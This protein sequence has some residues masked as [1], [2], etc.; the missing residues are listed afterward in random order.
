MAESHSS[1][2]PSLNH[3]QT[4][5]VQVVD[6]VSPL[7]CSTTA[8]DMEISNKD[9]RLITVTDDQVNGGVVQFKVKSV[10]LSLHHR[11]LIQD[12]TGNVILTVRLMANYKWQVFRGEST[13]VNDL[14]FSSKTE[15]PAAKDKKTR[16]PVMEVFLGGLHDKQK[17]MIKEKVGCDFKVQGNLSKGS[18]IVHEGSADTIVAQQVN[19]IDGEGK[20]KM[21]VRVYPNIDQAFMV[22][23]IVIMDTTNRAAGSDDALIASAMLTAF[24]STS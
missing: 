1:V 10:A 9:H 18:F 2:H 14:I 12:P 13:E 20:E 4:A 7:Y 23:L 15:F 11:K 16:A 24:V 19:K 5:S 6:V 3:H 21:V 8:V 17:N 22:A